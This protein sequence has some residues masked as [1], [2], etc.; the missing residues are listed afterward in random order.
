[1]NSVINIKLDGKVA[2]V[3]LASWS[4]GTFSR[5]DFTDG[6]SVPEGSVQRLRPHLQTTKTVSSP[7]MLAEDCLISPERGFDSNLISLV[8]IN[9]YRKNIRT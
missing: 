8:V 3:V 1:M 4:S 9:E 7:H 5:E 2:V 6:A